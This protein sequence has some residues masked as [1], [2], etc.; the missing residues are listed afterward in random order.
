MSL[1]QVSKAKQ[2]TA[3]GQALKLLTAGVPSTEADT[4]T[5]RVAYDRYVPRT[6]R[7]F[8]CFCVYVR[9]VVWL[10]STIA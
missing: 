9:V 10:V 6:V 8:V 7:V 4:M 1:T 5:L 2:W 3:V